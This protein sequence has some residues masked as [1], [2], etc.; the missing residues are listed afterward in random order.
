MLDRRE[1]LKRTGMA[2]LGAAAALGPVKAFALD[3]VTQPFEN[4][5]RPLVKYPPK[6]PMNRFPVHD[7]DGAR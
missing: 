2:A 5:E 6:R 1:M 4:G 7:R 3:T